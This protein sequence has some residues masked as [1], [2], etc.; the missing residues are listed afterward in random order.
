MKR[1]FCIFTVLIL[2]ALLLGTAYAQDADPVYYEPLESD[3]GP[4]TID[5]VYKLAA[6]D[7]GGQTVRITLTVPE[8]FLTGITDLG[9]SLGE[10]FFIVSTIVYGVFFPDEI[11]ADEDA[12]ISLLFSLPAESE[13]ADY[14]F[15]YVDQVRAL[16]KTGD[17]PGAFIEIPAEEEPV[18]ETTA[19]CIVPW[20]KTGELYHSSKYRSSAMTLH[21]KIAS[22]DTDSATYVKIY[23]DSDT[24]VST[25]FIAGSDT[26]STDLPGGVYSIKMGVGKTWYGETDAFGSEGH[27]ETMVF[28]N[29]ETEVELKSGYEYTLTIN[30]THSDPDAE[31][32]NSKYTEWS[33]F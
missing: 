19:D 13:A 17:V 29:E 14:N 8:D 4:I 23:A 6:A 24:L 20:P 31:G 11:A 26:V 33:D 16:V 32:V 25:M 28:D 5:S 9:E 30:T 3:A 15:V 2:A 27:Y 12:Q 18:E 10:Q 1:Q 7:E 21:I 22:Q